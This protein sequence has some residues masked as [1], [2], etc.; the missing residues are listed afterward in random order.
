[1]IIVRNSFI[2]KLKRLIKM[3]NSQEEIKKLE[4]SLNNFLEDKGALEEIIINEKVIYIKR[5][6]S[7]YFIKDFGWTNAFVLYCK[8]KNNC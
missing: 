2:K 4:F 3:D 5:D 8:F 6:K 7:M 1:M